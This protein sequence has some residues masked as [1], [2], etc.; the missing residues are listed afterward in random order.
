MENAKVIVL[1]AM[2]RFA[3]PAGLFIAAFILLIVV[4]FG[5]HYSWIPAGCLCSC[6]ACYCGPIIFPTWLRSGSV[7]L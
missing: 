6:L 4:V 5:I 1:Y 7:E 2:T 3:V